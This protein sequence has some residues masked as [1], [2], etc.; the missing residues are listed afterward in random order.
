MTPMDYEMEEGLAEDGFSEGA[1]IVI[2]C[3]AIASL[4][5]IC[6]IVWGCL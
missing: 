4:I 2:S 6:A 3:I 5:V 1:V